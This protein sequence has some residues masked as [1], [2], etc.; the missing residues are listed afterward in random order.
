[1]ISMTKNGNAGA[2][3]HVS[4]KKERRQMMWCERPLALSTTYSG[5]SNIGRRMYA[6][7][8]TCGDSTGMIPVLRPGTLLVQQVKTG[9]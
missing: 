9:S 8:L 7:G 2:V 4:G 6:Q 5:D 1:M 3:V